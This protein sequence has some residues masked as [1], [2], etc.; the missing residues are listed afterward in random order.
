VPD[1]V[2]SILA[3]GGK[4]S[5]SLPAYEPRP[6]Q[7]EMARAV[8]AAFRASRHLVCE[9][10]T[11]VGKSFAYLVPAIREAVRER[12]RIVVSTYTIS[13][14]EQLIEKDLPFLKQVTGE[15]FLA[16]LVKGR[17]NYLC[18]RRLE[19]ACA[20]AATLF[21]TGRLRSE[22]KRLADWALDTR[23]GTLSDLS[24]APH[25][26]V[27]DRVCAEHGNCRG[28]R[29]EHERRCFYQRARRRVHR[30]HILVVNHALFFSDLAIRAQGAQGVLPAFDRV[31][32]D[33]AH[34]LEG[35]ACDQLGIAVS[36]GQV[37]YLLRGIWRPGRGTGLLATLAAGADEARRACERA[38]EASEAL[39][40]DLL[41]WY[42]ADRSGS[43]RM[44]EPNLVR[45]PLSP[46]L[47]RLASLLKDL[48]R[49]ATDEEDQDE[50]ASAAQR[51]ASLGEAV[52]LFLTQSF[53]GEGDGEGNGGA[54]A[55]YWVEVSGGPEAAR[56]AVGSEPA[57]AWGGEAGGGAAQ[58]AGQS[59]GPRGRSKAKGARRDRP[60]RVYLRASPI[61][62]GPMLDHLLWQEV[63]SAVLTSATLAA[64][65]N[66]EFAYV[67]QR[68]SLAEADTLREGS[69]FDY[70]EQV[71]LYVEADLPPPNAPDYFD[72]AVAAIERYLDLSQGRAFVLFTSYRMLERAAAHL[73]PHLAK[74]RWTLLVQGG[75]LPRGKMLEAFRRDTHSVLF[76]TDTFWQGVDVPGAALSNVIITRLPFAVPDRPLVQARI[77]QIRASGGN[78]FNDYQLPEA[79]LKFKQGFGRLIR[80]AD[81]EGMVVVLD[82]RIA[83]KPYGRA[84]L[85]ALP[86]CQVIVPEKDD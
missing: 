39:F 19:R 12:R 41:R 86:K 71:R 54:G 38:H 5:A 24:P 50:L 49:Q 15:D 46:A 78:P 84:F 85:R 81:D 79:V 63:P 8:D 64:A 1:Y 76:G 83:S 13:L 14:Q 27:W 57:A 62:V 3:S 82:S 17:S 43:G 6:Q 25:P 28:R 9:A 23:D 37:E 4:V 34:N 11:G 51:A 68:L 59:R 47:G 33:E 66:D 29:C 52:H 67:R 61:H 53:G 56:E 16:V 77:E 73:R 36:S 42:A 31:V 18:L 72:Q 74:R 48:A 70:E 44:A 21:E 55:V 2:E 32:F 69:P 80:S 60:P 45:D 26:A 35:V 75:E 20:R 65:P 58:A 7:L 10:G 22:L 30:A 40:A